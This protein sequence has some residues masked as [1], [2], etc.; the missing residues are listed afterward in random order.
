MT[1]VYFSMSEIVLVD[2]Q[3]RYKTTAVG[4]GIIEVECC[5]CST[6]EGALTL[7]L[8]SSCN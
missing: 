1:E 6:S 8:E 4:K 7:A 2:S 5:G 3:A